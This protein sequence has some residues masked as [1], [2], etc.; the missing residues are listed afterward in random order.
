MKGKINF[1]QLK[2][3]KKITKIPVSIAGGINSETVVDAVKAGAD[4]II[5]G[6]AITK[7][8]NVSRSVK[9]IKLAINKKIKIKS[10]LYN[11]VREETKLRKI[12]NLVSTANISDAMHRFP[13][14]SGLISILENQ[15]IVGR[16]V[17]V[18][19]YPGDWSKPVQAIDVATQGDVIVIDAGGVEPAVWG[20]LATNSAL[21]KKVAGVIIWGGIRDVKEIKK[22]RF[23]AFAKIITPQ[24]G[25]PKGFGEINVP[26]TISGTKI[27]PG[28][29]IIAD[30]DGI[31]VIPKNEVVEIT[32]RAMDVL[33]RENRLRKEILNGSTL[34][35]T[36]Y[37]T[38]WEKKS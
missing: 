8:Q 10:L 32:N 6:G 34:A 2:Q 23:P 28:D 7:S 30:G 18:R 19:T 4:I 12:L 35:Q 31:M 17:T 16:A 11:R 5:V 15:K 27:F 29:W 1:E 9:E 21:K 25:E 37:L 36:A 26:I 22:L 20:E 33:E 24:A 38:K 3:V 14:I 13:P